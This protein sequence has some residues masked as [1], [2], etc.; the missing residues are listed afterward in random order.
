MFSKLAEWVKQAVYRLVVQEIQAD[1][2]SA[3]FP[4]EPPEMLALEPPKKRGR[5][6]T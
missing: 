1:F 5:K 6:K 4:I 2:E 3:G